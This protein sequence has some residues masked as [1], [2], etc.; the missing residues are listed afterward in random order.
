MKPISP[1]ARARRLA[2]LLAAAA[3]LAACEN[4]S[5]G[6]AGPLARLD[7]VSGDLQTG[8][9]GTQLAQPLVVRVLDDDGDPIAGQLVNFVVA[10]GGG[11]VFAGAAQTNAD[12]RAQELWTLGTTAGDTQR[13]EVRAVDPATGA[14]RVY[15]TF[16]A[17]GTPGAAAQISAVGAVQ[18]TGGAATLLADSLRVRVTDAYGNG[19][20]GVAVAWSVT[21]GGGSISPAQPVTGPTGESR[22]A[23]TLGARLDSV[24]AAQAAIGSGARVAFTATPT[25]PPGAR[26]VVVA[27]NGQ[28]D[29]VD[30]VLPAPV[31]VELQ[32]SDARPLAGAHLTWTPRLPGPPSPE[33]ELVQADSATGPGGRASAIVRLGTRAGTQTISVRTDL[34]TAAELT[35]HAV[36]GTTARVFLVIGRLALNGPGATR[37]LQP[38]LRDGY[39]NLSDDPIQFTSLDPGVL[40]V[41]AQ[42]RVTAVAVGEGQVQAAAGTGTGTAFFYVYPRYTVQLDPA[43]TTMAVGD[44]IRLTTSATYGGQPIPGAILQWTTP[45]PSVAGVYSSLTPGEGIVIGLS[46]GTV[47]VV[48][49]IGVDAGLDVADTAT[50]TVVAGTA[51]RASRPGAPAVRAAP[52]SS[53]RGPAAAG[54]APPRGAARARTTPAGSPPDSRR[55]ARP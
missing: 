11:Q 54:G 28:T 49:R 52:P 40:S 10:A 39:G 20:P 46:P 41:D 35:A 32:T 48:V 19:I 22:A 47:R 43:P 34:G 14:P 55:R 17:V 51:L 2:P 26:L 12:G 50:I 4:P 5:G 24:H 7:V 36:A 45:D 53:L 25:M 16:R 31:T 15:G 21:A 27:G 29:T 30:T 42:G 23:W 44:T 6:G 38:I 1:S 37:Q 13:V 9:V 33:P 3:V 18:R 8:P